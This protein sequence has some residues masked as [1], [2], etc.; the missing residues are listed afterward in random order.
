VTAQLRARE[1]PEE[2]I[3]MEEVRAK[4][5]EANASSDRGRVHAPRVVLPRES[6]AE[7]FERDMQERLV[8]QQGGCDG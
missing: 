3:F 4:L 5:Y 2:W 6:Y 8:K 7:V 1:V